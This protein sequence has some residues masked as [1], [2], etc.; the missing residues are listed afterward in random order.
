[1]KRSLLAVLCVLAIVPSALAGDKKKKAKEE[2]KSEVKADDST[3]IHWMTLDD[4]QVA[5]KKQPKKV[6]M[7]VYT[8]WCGWCKVMDK[9]TFSNKEVIRYMNKNFYAVRLN[10]ERQDSVMFMGKMYGFVPGMRANQLA[11]D[12]LGGRMSYPTS[13]ILEENFQNP[14]PIPGYLNVVTMEKILKYLGENI[15]KSKQFPDYEKEFVATWEEAPQTGNAGT[16]SPH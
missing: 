12:L 13:V 10:A 15:Y 1:M 4:V 5:M 2:Q 16:V 7:D 14:A 3:E 9:K 8:D 6:Y 11:I